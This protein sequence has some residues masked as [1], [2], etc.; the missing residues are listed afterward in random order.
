[1]TRCREENQRQGGGNEIK[2]RST[3]YTPEKKRK[4]ERE[5]KRKKERTKE[6]K[7]KQKKTKD[8]EFTL[9]H[10]CAH[11]PADNSHSIKVNRNVRN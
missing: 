10:T 8:V 11:K 1:M 7:K 6:T 3:I 5:R 2:S 9:L 4:N